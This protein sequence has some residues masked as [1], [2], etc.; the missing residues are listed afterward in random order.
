[1]FITIDG[2]SGAGKTT[3]L[4]IL[5]KK[6]KLEPVNY[7]AI[8]NI[9]DDI[10]CWVGTRSTYTRAFSALQAFHNMPCAE[11]CIIDHF[12]DRFEKLHR[13]T[14][15]ENFSKLLGYFRTGMRFNNRREPDLSI[16]IDYPW[17]L[18]LQRGMERDTQMIMVPTIDSEI[19]SDSQARQIFWRT[20]DSH[21]AYFH[22][23]N[24]NQSVEDVTESIMSLIQQLRNDNHSSEVL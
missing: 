9:L 15:E 24:G 8:C 4:N 5:A 12:W 22:R 16:F 21:L 20:I 17:Q 7:A 10:L 3:Q 18:G 1:M 23:V 13:Y 14:S 2:Y 6:L 11:D 19:K